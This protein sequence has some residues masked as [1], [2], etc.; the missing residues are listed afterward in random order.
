MKVS[1]RRLTKLARLALT[2]RYLKAALHGVFAAIE[3][4]HAL[5]ALPEVRT[6]IDVG[7]HRGQFSLVARKRFPNAV[8]FAFEPQARARDKYRSAVGIAALPFAIGRTN[9]TTILN[10]PAYSGAASLLPLTQAQFSLFPETGSLS[11]EEVQVRRL[12]EVVRLENIA[13]P[14]L[15]KLDVQG[16]ELEILRDIGPKLA[17]IDYLIVEAG[18]VACYEGQ[19]LID[20]VRE[21]LR[22]NGFSIMFEHSPLVGA[23]GTITQRDL[24]ACR[25]GAR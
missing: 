20:E 11:S 22:A 15:L 2:P 24:V 17:H 6:V 19:P 9:G 12:S 8:L 23:D 16:Y 1:L 13:R 25:H 5:A 14:S 21:F 3:H 4:E 18:C 7:A 10:V